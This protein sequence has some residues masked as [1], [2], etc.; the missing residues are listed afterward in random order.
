[1]E[2]VKRIQV[3]RFRRVTVPD[4]HI[5]Y[6]VTVQAAVRSWTVWRRY[7]DF[8]ALHRALIAQCPNLP[9]PPVSLPPKSW[10]AVRWD[11]GLTSLP[12]KVWSGIVNP[13]AAPRGDDDKGDSAPISDDLREKLETRRQGLERYLQAILEADDHPGWRESGPWGRFLEIPDLRPVGSRQRRPGNQGSPDSSTTRRVIGYAGDDGPLNASQWT[14]EYRSLAALNREIR[15]LLVKR[16]EGAARNEVSVVHQCTLRAKQLLAEAGVRG[17][18]LERSLEAQGG[19]EPTAAS[20]TP[21]NTLPAGE[22]RRR[23]DALTTWR[24]EVNQLNRRITSHA[25]GSSESPWGRSEGGAG[26]YERR[27]GRYGSPSPASSTAEAR[28]A[29]KDTRSLA[30]ESTLNPA[31]RRD[32]LLRGAAG[33]SARSHRVF[34][35]TANSRPAGVTNPTVPVETEETKSRGNAELLL[36]QKDRMKAQ[37]DQVQL[38]SRILRRQAEV[39]VAIGQ[40]LDIH[41]QLLGEF[42]EDLDR[43]GNKLH[44]ARKQMNRLQ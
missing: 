11:L 15:H 34:G 42:S 38:F 20:S 24:E 19:S 13:S 1:M 26:A 18:H 17:S 35:N 3:T 5:Q 30:E 27:S 7:S 10:P 28:A 41:N 31:R 4:D 43:T 37:D 6:Q 32:D 36:L 2:H 25:T 44:N 22:Y 16:D 14:D 39:G 40:E 23:Q 33:S 29:T 9:S 12:T 8:E 21:S